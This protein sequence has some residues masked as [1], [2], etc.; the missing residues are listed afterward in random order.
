M[1]HKSSVKNIDQA[2]SI[3]SSS[4]LAEGWKHPAELQYIR[5]AD[6]SQDLMITY[7]CQKAFTVPPRQAN[8]TLS[9]TEITRSHSGEKI[10][11]PRGYRIPLMFV[12]KFQWESLRLV[13]NSASEWEEYKF[14]IIH[15]S[16]LCTHFFKQAKAAAS[17]N[18]LTKSWRSPMFDRAL[19]RFYRKWMVSREWS[20]KKFWEEFEED[21]YQLDVLKFGE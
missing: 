15:L 2:N 6:W 12:A 14:D 16:R 18:K 3:G 1:G 9:Y 11:I 13:L 5:R 10:N 7:L 4:T 21:E 20:V 17:E 19:I 8:T